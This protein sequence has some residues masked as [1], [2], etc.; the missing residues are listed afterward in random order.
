VPLDDARTMTVDV[1]GQY[2]RGVN[3]HDIRL[4]GRKEPT[5][6][7]LWKHWLETHAKPHKKSWREDERQYNAFLKRWASRKL[8]AIT[9]AAVQQ[10][11]RTIGEKHGHYAANRMLALL[12]AMF[13]MASQVGHRGENPAKGV[14]RFKEES[15]DRF[16]SAD[17]LERF[18]AALHQ[19]PNET[20]KD[21]FFVALLTGARRANVQA[22]RWEN[23][24]LEMQLWRIPGAV[25]KSGAP[26]VVPL[27]PAVVEIVAR[28]QQTAGGS[29]WV[30]ASYGKTGHLVEPKAAWQRLLKR[31]NLEDLHVHDLRRT[32]GSWQAMT[33]AS[34]PIIGK[35]LGHSQPSTTAIYARLQLDP[36]RQSVQTAADA[37]LAADKARNS[38]PVE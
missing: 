37:I 5:L 34:L 8:S 35:S 38:Q 19:E 36:V 23:L 32:L 26:I 10:L 1:L 25:A 6:G 31:A 27:V 3:P 33:G 9:R 12:S 2:A 16:L 22:L 28:R 20:I 11:H 29:P 21:F 17:E 4:A 14:K 24:N 18:F 15:R 30:F 13:A 7:D